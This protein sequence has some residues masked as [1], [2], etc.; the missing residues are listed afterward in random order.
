MA[1]MSSRNMSNAKIFQSLL[2]AEKSEYQ[3]YEE[4]VTDKFFFEYAVKGT[5]IREVIR[6]EK[7]DILPSFFLGANTADGF[8]PLNG[9]LLLQGDDQRLFLI[10]GGP[11]TGKSSLMR[12]VYERAKEENIP[13]ERIFCSSDPNSLDGIVLPSLR[14]IVLDATPPHPFELKYPGVCGHLIDMGQ[15]WDANKLAASG[16]EIIR[17]SRENAQAHVACQRF[18]SVAAALKRQC[19]QS[20]AMHTDLLRV[21]RCAKRICA[22]ML[23]LR[24]EES[25]Q[26]RRFLSACTPVGIRVFYE[27][28]TGLCP[29]IIAVEDT[30][31]AVSAAF[32]RTVLQ[33]GRRRGL[34]MICCPCILQPDS[35]PEHILLPDEGIAFFTSNGYHPA[36]DTALRLIRGTRFEDRGALYAYKNRFSFCRRAMDELLDGAVEKLEEAKRL[37]DCLESYY[38][39][40]MDFGKAEKLK[41]DLLGELFDGE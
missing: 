15:C 34:R 27:T 26:S 7:H 8:F 11:G 18:L 19:M 9:D 5:H 32:M 41:I 1:K 36:P 28:L 22:K 16:E 39:A 29:Q 37:H 20:A 38:I 33:E 21:D 12:A 14:A 30:F 24:A 13:V 23:P 6:M 10:K 40:A 35:V 25:T 17:V 2:H 3:E 31:G 4:S